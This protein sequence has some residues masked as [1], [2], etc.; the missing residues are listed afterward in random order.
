MPSKVE[1]ITKK[2]LL[3]GKEFQTQPAWERKRKF[4]GGVKFCSRQCAI[5]ARKKRIVKYCKYC[6]EPFEIQLSR[7]G[8]PGHNGGMCGLYCSKACADKG[9]GGERSYRWK[10]GPPKYICVTCGKE[11]TSY[12]KNPK[13][14]S[15]PCLGEARRIRFLNRDLNPKAK[16]KIKV[17]CANCGKE[18]YRKPYKTQLNKT[19]YCSRKC[20]FEYEREENH[21]AW[22]GGIS[23]HYCEKFNND[24][25]NRVRAFFHYCCAECGMSEEDHITKIGKS[26]GVHHV[27]YDKATC[28]N[29]AVPFFV[30]LCGSCH[31]KTNSKTKRTYWQTHFTELINTKYGG[32]CYYT[33][34]EWAALNGELSPAAPRRICTDPQPAEARSH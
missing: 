22:Q 8:T 17:V 24:F 14:C 16:P 12:S 32:K 11:F 7:T 34:E 2:C 3:C 20:K 25:K 31:S 29:G 9:I 18:F 30:P 10:G 23:P 27:N 19:H 1:Q 13:Y 6:G 26:L 5:N 28:C 4:E 15:M 21:P 33:K